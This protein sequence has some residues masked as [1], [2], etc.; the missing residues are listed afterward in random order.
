MEI[1]RLNTAHS[2]GSRAFTTSLGLLTVPRVIT[3][4][5]YEEEGIELAGAAMVFF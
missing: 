2:L 3:R 5:T 1:R 4:N